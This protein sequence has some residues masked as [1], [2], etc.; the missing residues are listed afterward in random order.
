MLYLEIGKDVK[1]FSPI[2]KMK[3][4]KYL[5]VENSYVQSFSDFQWDFTEFSNLKNLILYS[6]EAKD[7]NG[8]EKLINNKYL[9]KCYLGKNIKNISALNNVENFKCD[10]FLIDI[11]GATSNIS[12]LKNIDAPI[13]IYGGTISDLS[14]LEGAKA[15]R[16][17]INNNILYDT[18]YETL[19][20]GKKTEIELPPI[21]TQQY[22]N[23]HVSYSDSCFN[24]LDTDKVIYDEVAKKIYIIPQQEGNANITVNTPNGDLIINYYAEKVDIPLVL[25]GPSPNYIKLKR[26]E[27]AQISYNMTPK[28]A[29]IKSITWGSLNEDIVSV[30]QEGNITAF[31]AGTGTVYVEATTETSRIRG[32]CTVEVYVP[33]EKVEITGINLNG[34]IQG[35]SY[36]LTAKHY[37]TDTTE[38]TT[39]TWSSSNESVATVDKDGLV[40]FVG[41]GEATIKVQVGNATAYHY[42]SVV[43]GLER[44]E[45]EPA[46]KQLY[47]NDTYKLEI[48]DYPENASWNKK[49]E[50]Y[51]S[52]TDIATVD[53]DGNVTAVGAGTTTIVAKA[54]EKI[55]VCTLKVLEKPTL[56]E[57]ISLNYSNATL[58]P[59]EELQLK[60]T[61]L[62]ST[63]TQEKA[64]NWV[65]TNKEVA[66]VDKNGKVTAIREGTSIIIVNVANK[67]AICEITVE[68][69]EKE[70]HEIFN[71]VQENS[72]YANSVKY[73]YENGI[74]TGLNETTFAPSRNLTRGMMV[75]LLYKMEGQ[76]KV[77]GTPTFPDIQDSSK[78]Y[79]KAVKWASDNKIVTGYENGNFGP[80][81]NITRTQLAVI[82]YR[83]AQYK[84]KDVSI[85]SDLSQFPDNKDVANWA[86]VAVIWAVEK[87]IITGNVNKQTGVKT[88]DPKQNATRAQVATMMER[89]CKNIGR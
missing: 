61:Y 45:I 32:Q 55:A 20:V 10:D 13:Q 46:E 49:V 47:V 33:V 22:L 70:I 59:N 78:Y 23:G 56:I 34:V 28:D 25:F 84:G 74:M 21:F 54:S 66:T 82:L 1:D 58:K 4:L 6:E 36:R 38:D 35:G 80:T 68:A 76:P 43:A 31:K 64:E 2:N 79:Y 3:K 30:D 8:I 75:M 72:W 89:Y 44:I 39:R 14:Q 40:R 53:K 48:K 42:V 50:W 60:V 51:S 71:D 73:V 81:D 26:G 15:P 24:L 87:G 85:K 16:I 63:A 19:E 83:Y 57:S 62:P 12:A 52:N 11:S 9:Q 67:T 17:S 65:S 5:W 7:L 37:P 77:E 86:K 27:K 69:K 41:L 18:I 88:L 29:T